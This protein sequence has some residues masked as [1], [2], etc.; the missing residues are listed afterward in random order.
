M[1]WIASITVGS[2][3][4]ASVSFSSIPSTFTHLQVRFFARST[5]NNAG[6]SVNLYYSL[7]SDGATNYS[8]HT[9]RGDGATVFASGNANQTVMFAGAGIA[10]AGSTASVFSGGILDLLDY[11]NTNKYKTA[12]LL[13]G[14]DRNGGGQAVF[15][16]G[17]WRSTSAVTTLTLSTDS[18]WAEFSRFDLYGIT[19]S[20]ETGA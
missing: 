9:L 6:S 16:S 20:Q 19:S 5:Y 18:N 2:G 10:D 11:A 8:Q 7:N 3:G 12:R 4:L 13:N 14:F 1:V 17:N 15:S